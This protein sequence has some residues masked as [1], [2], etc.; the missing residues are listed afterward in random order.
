MVSV[1]VGAVVYLLAAQY[2][3]AEQLT[4]AAWRDP[5]Y[6]WAHNY[7][8][9]LGLLTCSPEACSPRHA[10]MNASFLVLG[11]TI[12]TGSVLLRNQLR[13]GNLRRVAVGLLV[14]SGVGDLL[15]GSFPGSVAD[16]SGSNLAHTTGAVLA[17]VGGNAGI[18]A[19]GLLL[20]RGRHRRLAI[21]SIT[22]GMV[23]LAAFALFG[24]DVDL[25]L[26]TGTIERIAANPITVWMVVVG[27]LTLRSA[28]RSRG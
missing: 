14:A 5:D 1:R 12:A 19:T 16:A 9:D 6:S 3:V 28:G 7:I 15:V 18:L 20:R 27:A 25:G 23:G 21:Y 13:A 10:L 22:S 11:A 24:L 26:G 4:A 2:F 8:S 17:I